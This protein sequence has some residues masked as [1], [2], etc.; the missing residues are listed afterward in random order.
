MSLIFLH[1]VSLDT[2]GMHTSNISIDQNAFKAM[3]GESYG[4]FCSDQ[5]FFSSKSAGTVLGELRGCWQSV[6]RAPKMGL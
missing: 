1:A 6:T 4:R 5:T 2:T 3:V